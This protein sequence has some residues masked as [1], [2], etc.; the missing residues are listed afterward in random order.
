M[1]CFEEIVA[2]DSYE[3]SFKVTSDWKSAFN[4]EIRIKNVSEVTIEDWKLEFDFDH[5]IDRFWTAEILKQ[6]GNHYYIKNAGYNANIKPGE[7]VV[8][9]FAGN[10]GNVKTAPLNFGLSQIVTVNPVIDKERDSD[11]DGVLDW[12]EKLNGTNPRKRDTDGDKL[13]DF[14]EF[15]LHLNGLEK[16]SDNDGIE[17]GMEDT[18]EDKLQN[19]KE[20]E[21]GTD[22]TKKDTDGDGLLDGE[23]VYD[24]LTSPILEDTDGDTILDGD[25][26]LLGLNPNKEMSDGVIHDSERII[27]QILNEKNIAPELLENSNLFIPSISA[28]CSGILNN[29]IFIKAEDSDALNDNRAI[30]GEPIEV[31]NLGDKE[32]E[33]TISYNYNNYLKYSSESTLDYVILCEF[34]GGEF[35]PIETVR[36]DLNNLLT[37]KVK[38]GSTYFLLNVKEFLISVGID[39]EKGIKYPTKAS[40]FSTSMAVEGE[41]VSEPVSKLEESNEVPEEWYQEY[42]SNKLN[43]ESDVEYSDVNNKSTE[44]ASMNSLTMDF[45]AL[46]VD[47]GPMGQA[48][49]TFVIDTTGSMYSTIS[50][51]TSNISQFVDRLTT[52]YNVQVNFSII[53][54]KDITC[55]GINSTYI[56]KNGASN[57]Y[58][59][60][61]LFKQKLRNLM[62]NGGGDFPET[63]IDGLALSS[64]LDYR[65]NVNKF[66]VLVTDATYKTNNQYDISSMNEMAEI[67]KQQGISTSV[68]APTGYKSW[69]SVL[70]ESTDGIFAD[71]YGNFSNELMK[72]AGKIGSVVNDGTWVL[73]D[74]FQYV[75]LN[76]IVSPDNGVDTD[77]DGLSDYAELGELKEVNLDS[78]VQI[79]LDKLGL[80]LKDFIGKTS[81]NVYKYSSNP[82]LPDMD[83]DG[84]G[85]AID[86][87]QKDNKFSG[88]LKTSFSNSKVSY[89][90]DYREFFKDN[91]SYSE[92]LSQASIIF[93]TT[94]YDWGT[95]EGLDIDWLMQKHGLTNIKRYNI[96]N[97]YKDVDN[98]VT[99]A[100]IGRKR[101]VYNGKTKEIIS[102]VVRGTNGTIEE[103]S[104]NFDIGSTKQ[105]YLSPD[106]KVQE[107]HKG[108]DVAATRVLKCLSEYE[109][110]CDESEL[111]DKSAEKAYWITGHSRGAAITNILGARLGDEGK[112]V[113]AYAFAA[114]NT[115]TAGNASSYSGI[116]NIL[117]KDDFVPYLPMKD[118]GFTRYG[119]SVTISIADNYEKEWEKLTKCENMFGVVDYNIDAIGF[120]ETIDD[121]AK[122]VNNRDEC[123]QYYCDC[124]GDGSGHFFED[125]SI[126]NYGTSKASREEAIAKIPNNALP[127]CKITRY[128]GWGFVGWNFDVCQQP[129]YFMQLIAAKMADQIG[130]FRFVMELDVAD[131]YEI[132]KESLVL[133]SLGGLEHPH[134]PESYYILAKHIKTSQFY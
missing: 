108:F 71:V 24:Y 93:A 4:G 35:I 55:D 26:V 94:I 13:D 105:Q 128:D 76:D 133:S 47:A 9:G 16:D 85:D 91:T 33:V 69:Y 51:V 95:Y 60:V 11:S 88:E 41:I 117:N 38:S 92:T 77:M 66:V 2:N 53:D 120:D 56:V 96:A 14:V 75:K 30:I 131:K 37:S 90:M 115:T 123:Y 81:V 15:R 31:V 110:S 39:V 5:K 109:K 32:I 59:D 104:S 97:L 113:Y 129:E 107:N 122:V 12:L 40:M 64:K 114:P 65:N 79:M 125:Y 25:E 132:A 62:V 21:Y 78:F 27:E 100:Y 7:T 82:M 73:L 19:L 74:D 83:Y 99:E 6:E 57:W 49:I 20:I 10:P 119:K 3:I 23:E 36:D 68:I 54:Y 130:D 86:P 87:L 111:F 106:W 101:V 102:I 46:A 116:Y 70:F 63:A 118:W 121:M 58:S 134:Y 112:K 22:Y 29:Q 45:N 42:Y 28:K 89:T 44:I 124:H 48:D 127:F 1:L 50:N 8:L 80:S 72:L 43:I 52:E 67:L 34:N 98:D 17:D 18:D 126:T 103:W 61:N 84:I